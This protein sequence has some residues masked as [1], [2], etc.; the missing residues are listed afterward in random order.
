MRAIIVKFRNDG[1]TYGEIAKTLN[2]S[3]G[4][5]STLYTI[6]GK[7][8]PQREFLGSKDPE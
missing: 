3:K 7:I 4:W 8:K 6:S 1:K 2:V 5:S